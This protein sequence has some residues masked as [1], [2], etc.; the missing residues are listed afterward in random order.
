MTNKLYRIDSFQQEAN[1]I[2]CAISY[3][4]DSEHPIVPGVCTVEMVRH[5]LQA[6][7]QKKLRIVS[8]ANIKFLQLI[9]PGTHPSVNITWSVSEDLYTVNAIL[10]DGAQILF[11]M[12]ADYTVQ[13]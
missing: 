1:S 2:T 12:S 6:A 3:N 11:K 7:L 13:E 9:T 8:A 5:L 10:K 4:A